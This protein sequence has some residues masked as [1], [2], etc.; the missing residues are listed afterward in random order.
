MFCGVVSANQITDFGN[1]VYFFNGYPEMFGHDLS[2]FLTDHPQQRVVSIAAYDGGIYG[3]TSG[4]YVVFENKSAVKMNCKPVY[5]G[6][7][8]TADYTCK[9]E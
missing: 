1:G 2:Q 3:C 4:Y 9:V 5:S 6:N 7:L 8:M